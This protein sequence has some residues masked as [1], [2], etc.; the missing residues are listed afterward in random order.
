MLAVT[1]PTSK[2]ACKT[3]LR[4]DASGLYQL[5]LLEQLLHAG[6]AAAQHHSPS[7]HRISGQVRTAALAYPPRCALVAASRLISALRWLH[8]TGTGIDTT[9]TSHPAH[10][11]I[12]VIC[13]I[14]LCSLRVKLL[15]SLVVQHPLKATDLFLA[16]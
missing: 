2:H 14:C 5:L 9:V 10:V 15:S 13:G 12:L 3:Y 6:A 1:W 11:C 4:Y 16:T 8:S 7:E